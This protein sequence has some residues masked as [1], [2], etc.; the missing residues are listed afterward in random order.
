MDPRIQR[1]VAIIERDPHQRLSLVTL[2][3]TAGLSSSRLRHKFKL[4]VGV[5]P[6]LY[7]RSVR[8]RMAAELLRDDQLSIKEVRA[9]IGLES[10]S[11]FTHLCERVYGHPPSRIKKR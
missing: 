2:A 1:V 11:Y 7:L 9:R 10:D 3:R 4:E 5:T 6:T 8:M